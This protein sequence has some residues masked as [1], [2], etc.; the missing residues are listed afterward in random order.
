[1]GII[2]TYSGAGASASANQ[3]S[4]LDDLLVQIPDNTANLIDAKDLRDSIYTIWERVSQVQTVASQSASASVYYTN[5]TPV[6]VTIGGIPAGTTF[7]NLTMDQMW[8]SLLYPYI[9]PTSTISGGSVKEYGSS[10]VSSLSW[11]VTKNTNSIISITVSN[12]ISTYLYVTPTGN[13]QTGSQTASVTQNVSGTLYVSATDGTT[14]TT[15]STTVTWSDAIYWGKY[16]TFTVPPMT[17]NNVGPSWADGA[18]VGSGKLI[19][20]TKSKSYNGVDGSGQYLVFMWPTSYGSPTFTIN[21]LPN[22]AF[23]KIGNGITYVNMYGY[24]NSY[25]VWISDTKQNSPIASFVIS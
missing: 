18:G 12:S 10:P 19:S 9:A 6:P 16:S 2:G 24:S 23:T 8:T 25:D 20:T 14:N 22:T 7:S 21:G 4:G 11:S 15:S 3:W 13:S 17:I 1:M 5:A